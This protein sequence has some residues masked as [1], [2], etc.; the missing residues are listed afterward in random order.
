MASRLSRLRTALILGV[1]ILLTALGILAYVDRRARAARARHGRRALLDPRR[2]PAPGRPGRGED[3]RRHLRHARDALAVPALA[4]RQGDRPDRRR[5]AEGDRLRRAVLGGERGLRL[6]PGPR[7]G[8][9][10]RQGPDRA[11]DHRGEREGRGQV[12]RRPAGGAGG[13]PRRPLRKR[14]L[15]VRRGRRDPAHGAHDRRDG[16][17]RRGHRRGRHRQAG[18]S[19]RGRLRGRRLD[20]LPRAARARSSPSRSRGS[21]GARPR[22]GSSATST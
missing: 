16:D 22:R 11:R 15:P 14:A 4:A 21:R 10:R 19:R 18:R 3:R 7:R 8:G 20:R 13:G 17:A 2:G 5:Q 6:R 1:G 12:P 9:G